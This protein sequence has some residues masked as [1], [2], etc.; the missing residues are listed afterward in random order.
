MRD[1]GEHYTPIRRLRSQRDFVGVQKL[2]LRIEPIKV[3]P[4][5]GD[6]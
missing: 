4:V 6:L 3:R 2:H 5:R 1:L